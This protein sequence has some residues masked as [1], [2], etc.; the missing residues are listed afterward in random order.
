MPTAA[1]PPNSFIKFWTAKELREWY[2]ELKWRTRD[3]ETEDIYRSISVPTI[4]Q[5]R[6]EFKRRRM[7]LV[8]KS[9]RSKE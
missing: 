5:T 1:H 2:K 7:K 6:A 3:K 4:E 8:L 9:R